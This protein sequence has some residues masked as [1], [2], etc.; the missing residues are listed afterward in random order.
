MD[1]PELVALI[2]RRLCTTKRG[3]FPDDSTLP[4]VSLAVEWQR[5]GVRADF[6]G[7]GAAGGEDS[8]E[9]MYEVGGMMAA[10]GEQLGLAC[11]SSYEVTN[12]KALRTGSADQEVAREMSCRALVELQAHYVLAMGHSLANLAGRVIAMDVDLRADLLRHLKTDFPPYSEDRK[13]W[14]QLSLVSKLQSIARS[15]VHGDMEGVVTPVLDL[16]NSTAWTVLEESRGQDFHRWRPQTAGL[17]GAASGA[18][19]AVESGGAKSYSITGGQLLGSDVATKLAANSWITTKDAMSEICTA[20]RRFEPSLR[21]PIE[22]LTNLVL[23][24]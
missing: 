24:P 12:W 1:A 11:L 23:T 15:C 9:R 6:W 18:F 21:S 19:G 7:M 17:R 10:I 13:D 20:M 14:I 5:V 4:F 8:A 2:P 16:A 22:R 3:K